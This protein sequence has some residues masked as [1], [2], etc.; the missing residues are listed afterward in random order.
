M[1]IEQFVDLLGQEKA[2]AI[3]RTHDQQKAAAAMDAAIRGGFKII[4]FTL[5]VP[6]AFEL[7]QDFSNRSNVVVGAGTVLNTKE[8]GQAVEAG[9]QFLVSP[10]VDKAVI[11]SA[12]EMGVASFPGTH[13]ATEMMRAH[14]YGATFCKLFPAPHGGPDYVKAILGPLPFLKI[15]PTNGA[16]QFNA[17]DW[18]KAGAFAVGFVAPL[19]EPRFIAESNWEAI[20]QRALECLNSTRN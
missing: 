18:I 11:H 6:G 12:S 10:V 14:H 3:L 2:S 13:T 16:D 4:E 17:G 5:T 9:A 8:A 15:V 20:E 19:F 7:I 1:T